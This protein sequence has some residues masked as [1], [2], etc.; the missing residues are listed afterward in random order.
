M[1]RWLR[2]PPLLP[3]RLQHPLY[4]GEWEV[5]ALCAALRQRAAARH[6]R[7]RNRR[8]PRR[9]LVSRSALPAHRAIGS[10]QSLLHVPQVPLLPPATMLPGQDRQ[11]APGLQVLCVP[12]THAALPVPSYPTAI[13]VSWKRRLWR[14]LHITF[15]CALR[16]DVPCAFRS[17]AAW[18][19]LPE[20]ML[21]DAALQGALESAQLAERQASLHPNRGGCYSCCCSLNRQHKTHTCLRHAACTL[22][23]V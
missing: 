5:Q 22:T 23:P 7:Q 19:W 14:V 4:P 9:Q 3:L 18:W 15:P 17:F 10:G 8:R 21:S 13:D 2:R 6:H 11:G 1:R 12:A 20:H 16:C